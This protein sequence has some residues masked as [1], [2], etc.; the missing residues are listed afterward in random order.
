MLLIWGSCQ[1]A[2]AVLH[3]MTCS[4]WLQRQNNF[5]FPKKAKSILNWLTDWRLLVSVQA[6]HYFMHW[7]LC[8]SE[9]IVALV[10]GACGT[11][12][13]EWNVLFCTVARALWE[14]CLCA[15]LHIPKQC[16]CSESGIARFLYSRHSWMVPS[17]YCCFPSVIYWCYQVWHLLMRLL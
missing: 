9:Q 8:H 11:W 13:P 12:V 5:P 7:S 3:K 17:L 1:V 6:S 2:F 15:L 14:M 10:K 4:E 16:V